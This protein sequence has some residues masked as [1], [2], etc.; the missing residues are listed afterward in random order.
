MRA[1]KSGDSLPDS[2]S[3]KI[4]KLLCKKAVAFYFKMC[5]DKYDT[6]MVKYIYVRG[7]LP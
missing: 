1:K 2:E 7:N 5:P 3:Q 6:D 4:V